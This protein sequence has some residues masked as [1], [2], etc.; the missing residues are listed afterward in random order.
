MTEEIIDSA[1]T[2][3][4]S[5]ISNADISPSD[6][7]STVATEEASKTEIQIPENWEQG[8]KEAFN[9]EY[10]KKNPDAKKDFFKKF[11]NYDDGYNS[12]F[13][14]LSKQR[15]EFEENSKSFQ[16][17][18]T[19]LHQ[20]QS[21][22]NSIPQ[23]M[24]MNINA[25]FG[26][27][28]QYLTNLIQLDKEATENPMAFIDRVMKN[29][30]LTLE[31]LAQGFESP[32]YKQ[33][34]S[35]RTH[36]QTVGSLREELVSQI[37]SEFET[38]EMQTKVFQMRDAKDDSGSLKYPHLQEVAPMMDIL[39]QGT[40]NPSFAELEKA[41]ES[42][43]YAD[44]N[45]RN[46][47]MKINVDT[48]TKQAINKSEVEKAKSIQGVRTSSVG[49]KIKQS[50]SFESKLEEELNKRFPGE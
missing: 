48:A 34:Q 6:S 11:K 26:S 15:K 9:H 35:Q 14:E 30:G 18:Q 5:G 32:K 10:F 3:D 13:S 22:E 47:I 12:K 37:R 2:L 46:N 23:D 36:E 45:I 33:M 50:Q 20:W 39:L 28:Q 4:N 31:D 42:A 38:R 43:C 24:R 1:S 8:L 41:Y 17:K 29:T 16:E 19:F 21:F 7:T 49:A 25:G 27:M 40:R 44:P